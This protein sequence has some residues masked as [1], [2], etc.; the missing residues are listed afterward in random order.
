[1]K[2]TKNDDQIQRAGYQNE[3]INF[4]TSG[5]GIFKG[6]VTKGDNFGLS[7]REAKTSLQLHVMHVNLYLFNVCCTPDEVLQVHVT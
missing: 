6:F 5:V 3:V 4:A 7:Q 2:E 1:M